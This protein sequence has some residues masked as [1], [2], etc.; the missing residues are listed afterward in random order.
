MHGGLERRRLRRR[1]LPGLLRGP[2]HLHDG[3]LRLQ[4]QLLR[5]GVP[6]REVPQRLFRQ[7]LL[8]QGH[9]RMQRRLPGLGLPHPRPEGRVR[10][11]EE[12][13]APAPAGEARHPQDHDAAGLPGELQRQGELRQLRLLRLHRRL[14][15]HRLSELLPEPLQRARRVHHG[16]VRLHERLLGRRLLAEDVLQRAR[17]LLPARRLRLRPGLHGRHVRAG[18][19]LHRPD[20]QRPRLLRPGLVQVRGRVGRA[21]LQGVAQGVRR[22]VPRGGRVRPR[23]GHLHVRHGALPGSESRR[24]GPP[25]DEGGRQHHAGGPEKAAA[26]ADGADRG[27]VQGGSGPQVQLPV[28][29]V[30][31][32]SG[33]LR[34]HGEVVRGAVRGVALPGLV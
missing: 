21:A 18:D 9:L 1:A 19:V 31:R 22:P 7:R 8:R 12:G 10:L 26:A 20:L 34:L 24:H 3:D 27:A 5:G 6:V 29:Q 11:R 25:D 13:G 2:R 4:R 30:G 23:L 32:H 15:R 14:L 17:R 33:R 28:W 16:H